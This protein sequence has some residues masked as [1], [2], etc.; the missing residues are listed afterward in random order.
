VAEDGTTTLSFQKMNGME[1]KY[2]IGNNN[3]CAT[4]SEKDKTVDMITEN[5]VSANNATG[6]RIIT[7][8]KSQQPTGNA[9]QQTP[10]PAPP[11]NTTPTH[12]KQT[13]QDTVKTSQSN[14]TPHRKYGAIFEAV[15]G[16]TIE[17]YLRTIADSIGGNDIKYASRLSGGRI[18]VY[19]AAESYVREICADGGISINDTYIKCRQYIMASKRVVLS[20]VIPDIPDESLIPLLQKFGKPTSHMSHFSISTTHPDLRHIKS[21]RRMINMIIP[22]MEKIPSTIHIKH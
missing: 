3:P 22:N 11:I 13:T 9:S 19:F 8:K 5:K 7:T 6:N 12:S 21:F 1:D 2:S 14:Y 16:L 15:D 4:T 18:C 10:S 20:N 17:Q